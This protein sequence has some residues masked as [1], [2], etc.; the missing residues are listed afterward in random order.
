MIVSVGVGVGVS[1]IV[2]VMV[3]VIVGVTV[4]VGVIEL[5][6]VGDGGIGSTKLK[7]KSNPTDMYSMLLVIIASVITCS[8]SGVFVGVIVG[9]GVGVTWKIEFS[10]VVKLDEYCGGFTDTPLNDATC[11]KLLKSSS[12]VTTNIVEVE[13]CDR[14]IPVVITIGEP[15]VSSI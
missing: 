6:G 1:V 14:V 8:G 4:G 5:V 7:Y 9:V 3:G 13:P 12:K 2:G 15:V 10:L 11:V